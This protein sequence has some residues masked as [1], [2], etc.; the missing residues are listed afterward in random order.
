[1]KHSFLYIIQ[2]I[3]VVS[4]GLPRSYGQ[5]VRG[6]DITVRVGDSIVEDNVGMQYAIAG[7]LRT[8]T[9]YNPSMTLTDS[10]ITF[11]FD[12]LR[13]D[14]IATI[15]TVY[16]TDA[17]SVV[18]L[19]QLGGDSTR[20]LWL[21]SQEA[22]FEDFG[23][24]YR[25]STEKGVI[26]HTMVYRYPAVD[27]GYDGRDTLYVGR[28][29]GL[30]GEKR[31][32]GWHYYRGRL[33]RREQ[34]I[35][36]SA[37][38][39]R[40]GALLHG[41]YVTSA[42]DTVWNTKGADSLYSAGVCGIGRDDSLGLMQTKSQIRHDIISIASESDM[43]D[44]DRIMAGHDGGA[45]VSGPE[46]VVIEGQEYEKTERRWKLRSS[47][48]S[49]QHIKVLL[50]ESGGI[51]KL[52]MVERG[53]ETRIYMPE[54]GDSVYYDSIAVEPGEDHFLALLEPVL[55]EGA[56]MAR[57]SHGRGEG[58]EP[59]SPNFGKD[60]RELRV[61]VV[62]NPTRGIYAVEVEQEEEEE[63]AVEVVDAAG[64]AVAQYSSGRKS[65]RY[66]VEDKIEGDGV[67]YVTV[68][69]NGQRKTVKLVVVR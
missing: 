8:T 47:S 45:V 35:E 6:A 43:G 38:A 39:I 32:C 46:R 7:A 26:I 12:S 61:K 37:L 11:V 53:G 14:G 2:L 65:D 27:S 23:I 52:L 33:S 4:V 67:Y 41:A 34:P 25:D 57:G 54:Y 15:M 59:A 36:E 58:S 69:S 62:P 18:G 64:R 66:R 51:E 31:F 16:E 10:A 20:V 48:G 9:N 63:I 22:S 40:Y 28:E 68:I 3:L 5:L 49:L 13:T 19:W 30:T 42:M 24:V 60:S 56:M 21:N 44:R 1:M 17:D 29:W 50:H 55:E